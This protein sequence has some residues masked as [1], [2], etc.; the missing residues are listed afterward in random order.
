MKAMDSRLWFPFLGAGDEAEFII[1][2]REPRE[3]KRSV[4]ALKTERA[5]PRLSGEREDRRGDEIFERM[6]AARMEERGDVESEM[7]AA[8][9]CAA[10]MI[11]LRGGAGFTAEVASDSRL[12]LDCFVSRTLAITL[13][14]AAR[15]ANGGRAAAHRSRRR[16]RCAP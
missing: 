4:L 12:Y 15:S 11:A 10:A 16:R 6:L 2:L 14:R 7:E 9:Q 1:C 5:F 8:A 3:G 13:E